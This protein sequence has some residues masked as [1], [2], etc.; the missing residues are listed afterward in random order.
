MAVPG[1]TRIRFGRSYVYINPDTSVS[2]PE[3]SRIGTW[4]LSR[5]TES[6][7]DA[8]PAAEGSLGFLA[9]VREPAG[10]TVGQLV[11]IDKDGIL[12][13]KANSL[14][15]AI[16]AGVVLTAG[17]LGDSVTVT[18][19]ESVAFFDVSGL[20]DGGGVEGYLETGTNYYL[21]TNTAGN[22]TPVPDI[23]TA[24]YVVAQVGTATGPNSMSIEIQS[25]IVI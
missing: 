4:R 20:V 3:L 25:P 12:L 16:V 1:E 5:D 6:D 13:A 23:T 8:G 19:N 18:R 9:V 22:W 21:S 10:V 14:D 17:A 11:T 2:T 24:G 15:T 7:D